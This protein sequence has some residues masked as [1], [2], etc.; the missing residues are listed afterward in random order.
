M[1]STPTP[2]AAALARAPTNE[3]RSGEQD[4]QPSPVAVGRRTGK[5]SPGHGPNR[6][7]GD[8]QALG[9]AA[10]VEVDLDEEQSSGDYAGVVAEKQPAEPAI[11]AVSTTL[12][13]ALLRDA[14]GRRSSRRDRIPLYRTSN[15]RTLRERLRRPPGAVARGALS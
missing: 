5:R 9:E 8:D 6:H 4:H 12:R 15:C 10:K 1:T 3:H 2:G 13:R 14:Q 7:R 11:A